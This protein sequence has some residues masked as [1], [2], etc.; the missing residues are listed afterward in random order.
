M[1][2]ALENF[3]GSAPRIESHLL[4]ENA[5]TIAK[6]CKLLSGALRPWRAPLFVETPSRAGTK[7]ALFRYGNFWFH[8]INEVDCVRGPLASDAYDRV[9]FTGEGAPRMT[10]N[11]VATSGGGTD[12]PT[13]AFLLGIPAP[14]GA[15][16]VALNG[17]PDPNPA[18]PLDQESRSYVY[19]F[20]SAYGEEGPPSSPS[21]VVTWSPGQTVDVGAMDTTVPDPADR[22]IIQ[23]KLYRTNTGSSGTEYQLVATIALANASVNDAVASDALGIVLPSIEWDAPPDDLHGL[24]IHP[25]GFAYGFSGKEVCLTPPYRPHA[26]PVSYRIP[27]NSTIVGGKTFGTSLLVVTEDLPYLLTGSD[28]SILDPER[29]EVGQSCVSAAGIV[30]MGYAVAYPGPDGL[31]IVGINGM[32]NATEE[33]LSRDDWQA[34]APETIRGTFFA[35]KYLG[36]YDNGVPGGFIF[37]PQ[38]KK[39]V[40]LGTYATAAFAD[41]ADGK[42]YIQVGDDLML[43]D[44]GAVQTYQWRSKPF[45]TAPT[46]FGAGKVL[47][48]DYTSLTLKVYADGVLKHTQAVTDAN[49]FRLPSGFVATDWQFDLTGTS[50]VNAVLVGATLSEL[51]RS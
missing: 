29:L 47:A 49:P 9:Y 11:D 10:A 26:W 3:V 41:P 8:W 30:D 36:F 7:L 40:T 48:D 24:G 13:T 2:I 22:K 44:G 18:E 6:N 23:K 35:G 42:L 46:N 4:P 34:F 50:N 1:L 32:S 17:S 43:W 5:A 37:D 45:R 20:V 21:T 31:V 33:I 51:R 15:P 39:F 28:P 12:Y 27:L 14:T 25:A 16:S 38:S 19:T